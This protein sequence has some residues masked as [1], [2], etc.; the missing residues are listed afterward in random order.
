MTRT[1]IVFF[2]AALLGAWQRAPDSRAQVRALADAGRLDDAERMARGG[3]ASLTASLGEVLVMRG[4]LS[5][6]D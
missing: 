3:G 1:W 5:E 4:R 2:T 6:A